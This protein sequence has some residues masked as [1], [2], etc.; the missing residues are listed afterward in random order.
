MGGL[1][2]YIEGV[3]NGIWPKAS[4][5]FIP[6]RRP[7][8]ML[9]QLHLVFSTNVTARS[10]KRHGV[11]NNPQLNCLFDNLFNWHQR[12]HQSSALLALVRGIHWWPV[13]SPQS[14]VDSPHQGRSNG[15]AESVS[16]SWCQTLPVIPW[17]HVHYILYDITVIMSLMPRLSH[18]NRYCVISSH[19][20]TELCG[21][22]I[23]LD[24]HF[25][26]ALK[27]HMWLKWKTRF[28]LFTDHSFNSLCP[29]GIAKMGHFFFTPYWRHQSLGY[30]KKIW[31]PVVNIIWCP[32]AIKGFSI[33][34]LMLIIKC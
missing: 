18:F 26:S 17:R 14:P 3:P 33:Q 20:L 34:L 4:T 22:N 31:M 6:D 21:R 12:N 23:K 16:T 2:I 5:H 27:W 32:W 30:L 29:G 28:C 11:S 8:A 15:N 25:S 10:H 1:T 19:L 7:D 13:D 9:H 24:F